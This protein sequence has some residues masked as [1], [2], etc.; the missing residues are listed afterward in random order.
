[1]IAT[2]ATIP[3]IRAVE[4]FL[5][6]EAELLDLKQWEAWAD[7]FT[8]DGTYWIPT[9]EN[10]ADPYTRASIMF[11]DRQMMANRIRRL[12]HPEIHAQTPPSRT[13]HLVTNVTVAP[14]PDPD[15]CIAVGSCFLMLEYRAESQFT[16]GGRFRYQL[17]GT[18]GDLKIRSKTVHL[19]NCDAAHH[20]MAIWF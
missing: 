20:L 17:A 12:R 10:Q 3:D 13:T 18:G 7:L 4:Q 5:Y 1:M 9:A 6:H 11:D 14:R 19:V 8:A 16:Y 2:T 15:G